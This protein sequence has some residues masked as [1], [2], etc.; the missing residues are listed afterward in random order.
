MAA[1]YRGAEGSVRVL[2]VDPWEFKTGSYGAGKGDR[3]FQ[4]TEFTAF[5]N[6]FNGSF[7]KALVL[8]QLAS[9]PPLLAEERLK[10]IRLVGSSANAFDQGVVRHRGPI[11]LLLT[12][13]QPSQEP[14]VGHPVAP[15]AVQL[16][17]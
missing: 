10:D 5:K 17:A 3:V 1:G 12:I 15:K 6:Y 4:T 16:S 13:L 14:P 8:T 9:Q 2:I 11:R 7:T